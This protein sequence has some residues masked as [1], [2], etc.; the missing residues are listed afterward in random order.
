MA[1]EE[2][3]IGG[4]SYDSYDA[5]RDSTGEIGHA[6]ASQR[7]MRQRGFVERNNQSPL[8]ETSDRN[9]R[10]KSLISRAQEIHVENIFE[11][12]DRKRRILQEIWPEKFGYKG[13]QDISDYTASEIGKL[14][15]NMFRGAERAVVKE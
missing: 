1:Y 11:Q 6:L 4:M 9:S 12:A 5:E 7:V 3:T 8:S 10:Y 14:F 2:R 13:R 15:Y